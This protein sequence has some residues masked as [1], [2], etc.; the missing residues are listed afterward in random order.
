M[1]D[2]KIKIPGGKIPGIGSDIE[3]VASNFATEDSMRELISL[4]NPRASANPRARADRDA[5]RSAREAAGELD[6]L[7]DQIDLTTDQID[8][9]GGRL[10][11]RFDGVGG[12]ISEVATGLINSFENIAMAG[13]EQSGRLSKTIETIAGV[14]RRMLDAFSEITDSIPLIGGTL[15]KFAVG[16][17]KLTLEV[18]AAA[19]GFVT[20]MLEA[21]RDQQRQLFDSGVYFAKGIDDAADLASKN[22]VTIGV[23]GKA[24]ESAK[25]SL[26]L[27]AGGAAAGL[28]KTTQAFG[29]LDKDGTN[30]LLYALGYTQDEILSGM[31]DFGASAALAGKDLSMDELA[32][33][34]LEYLKNQKE[35]SRITG[36]DIKSMKAKQEA[37]G[38]EA[39]F[40]SMLA[41]MQPEAASALKAMIAGLPESQAELA[42][43]RILGMQVTDPALAYL[44]ANMQGFGNVFTEV[45]NRAR[46]GSLT[47]ASS[48]DLLVKANVAAAAE[49]TRILNSYGGPAMQGQLLQAGGIIGDVITRLGNIRADATRIEKAGGKFS[50]TFDLDKIA[51]EF[52]TNATSLSGS[53]AKYTQI[54][55][56]IANAMQAAAVQMTEGAIAFA[57]NLPTLF[58]KMAE[59]LGIQTAQNI[60]GSMAKL[61][62]AIEKNGILK[63][64]ITGADPYSGLTNAQLDAAGITR[65]MEMSEGRGTPRTTAVYKKRSQGGPVARGSDYLVG[66]GGKPEIFQPSTDGRIIPTGS[67]VPVKMSEI[68]VF[69]DMASK[70]DLLTRINGAMLTAMESNNRLTRQGN[71][72]AG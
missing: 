10:S 50:E 26:R 66:E 20:G 68:A 44:D 65:S 22:G 32:A 57:K 47:E 64:G 46:D 41:G 15:G 7:G 55:T 40:Q 58:D 21:L 69:R 19:A 3:L 51:E 38:R 61:S 13:D 71:M 48:K 43:A 2:N 1:A 39:A 29:K 9:A 25:D 63:P 37:L 17:A 11:D 52:K 5:A 27:F 42:K 31:A 70:L 4:L 30:K 23:L 28:R 14:G 8:D 53:I 6:E 36:E 18:G 54:E 56:T 45:G 35:L 60:N 34:S 59:E 62:A 24:A 33:G 16:T 12:K 72:L 49:T 67:A